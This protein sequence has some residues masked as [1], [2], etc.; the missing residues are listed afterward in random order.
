[1]N[2]CD[3]VTITVHPCNANWASEI[4]SCQFFQQMK[5]AMFTKCAHGESGYCTNPAAIA[6]ANRESE[7]KCRQ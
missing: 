3:K 2:Y 1:V 5:Q 7:T 6:A 4:K